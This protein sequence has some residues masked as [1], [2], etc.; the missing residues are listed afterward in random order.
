MYLKSRYNWQLLRFGNEI[1]NIL[2]SVRIWYRYSSTIF[3]NYFFTLWIIIIKLNSYRRKKYYLSL[4]C[5][6]IWIFDGWDFPGINELKNENIEILLWYF[7]NTHR[8]M[9]TLCDSIQNSFL[10]DNNAAAGREASARMPLGDISSSQWNRKIKFQAC[11]YSATCFYA[12]L[13]Y[14]RRWR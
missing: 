9:R 11:Q 5:V 4:A 8:C 1:L 7:F 14:S 3:R 12:P 10:D 6:K 2:F 13:P